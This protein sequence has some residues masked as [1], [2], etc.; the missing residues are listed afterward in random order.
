[1][2]ITIIITPTA[3]GERKSAGTIGTIIVIGTGIGIAGTMLEIDTTRS[4]IAGRVIAIGIAIGTNGVEDS[5]RH[6]FLRASEK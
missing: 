2:M 6:P 4:V 5:S 1:M 3:T